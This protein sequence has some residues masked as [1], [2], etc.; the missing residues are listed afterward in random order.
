MAKWDGIVIGAGPNGLVTA[1]YLAKAG[2]KISVL[3]RRFELGGGLCSEQVTLPGFVHNTHAVYHPMVDYAPIFDDLELLKRFNVK[4][5]HPP[6]VMA[7]PLLNGGSLGIFSDL[8]KTCESIAKFSKKD[9]DTY[10]ELYHQYDTAMRKF[11]GPA[12]YIPAMPP[13]EQVAELQKSEI[14]SWVNEMAEKSPKELIDEHFENE[15]VKALMLYAACMWGLEY[16]QTG[17]GFLIP[18]YINRAS[19]YRLCVGGSHYLASALSK[20]IYE[21]GGRV[22]TA[23]KIKRV[24][25][26]NGEATGVEL[27]D[28]EI[29]EADRFIVSSLD[30]EQTFINL[31][32]EENLDPELAFSAKGWQWEE[33][34]LCVQHMAL[35][36]APQFTAASSEPLMNQAF[37]YVLGYETDEELI[38]HFEAV[39]KGEMIQSG[40]NCSFPSVL[41]PIEAPKTRKGQEEYTTGLISQIAPYE[42]KDGGKDKWY[43]YKFKKEI[44]MQ[45]LEILRRYAPNM[46]EENVFM[47]YM[48]TPVDIENKIWDMKRGSIKQGAYL[49]LQMGYNRPNQLCSRHRTPIKKFYVNGACTYSGGT[50]I[51]GPGYLAANAIAEDLGIKKWWKEPKIADDL[52]F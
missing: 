3:E 41:D 20:V 28:G 2:L 25:L 37:I 11:I 51:Y 32:G 50:L 19:N 40:Y 17:L 39:R 45:Q 34:S 44:A 47:R 31:I 13:L 6:L 21:N 30:P 49:T 8:N 22:T 9:A 33:E 35:E 12:T 5:I 16:D 10:R 27:A 42:L 1:A 24:I 43:N 23:Q 7:M 14:G 38:R 4:F 46:T 15:H 52:T 26:K 36:T 29:I 18:L 48:T